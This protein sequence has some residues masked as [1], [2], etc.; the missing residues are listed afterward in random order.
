MSELVITR[1]E[2]E[3]YLGIEHRVIDVPRAGLEAK[4]TNGAGKTSILRA[5]SACLAGEGVKD[6][7]IHVGEDRAQ[8]LVKIGDLI[9]KRT[10]PRGGKA[11]LSVTNPDGLKYPSPQTFLNSLL[12]SSAIDPVGLFLDEPAKRR[13]R[14]Q[15]A[16]PMH[17]TMEQ[18][19]KWVPNL[20]TLP[21]GVSLDEHGLDVVSKIRKIYFDTRA[22]ANAVAKEARRVA[23]DARKRMKEA[24]GPGAQTTVTP[25]EALAQFEKA[26]RDVQELGIRQEQ[27]EGSRARTATAR[28]RATELRERSVKAAADA[29]AKRP[30][31]AAFDAYRTQRDEL[32]VRVDLARAELEK[33]EADLNVVERATDKLV[34]ADREATTLEETAGVL[35]VQAED[36]EAT[37]A[38]TEVPEVS[39]AQIQAANET[40]AKAK[41]LQV[42]A[43]NAAALQ[44]LKADAARLSDAADKA[45]DAAGELDSVVKA[46]TNEAPAE[47]IS[48]DGGIP[49]V[50]FE[51]DSVL[52]DDKKLETC[53]EAEKLRF[54]VKI[55]KRANP[56]SRILICDGV[57]R[58]AP[59]KLEDFYREC[60]TDGW[61]ILATRVDRGELVIEA[62]QAG[63]EEQAAE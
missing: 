48:G 3:N 39:E 1:I 13:A 29:V 45:E 37:L 41:M 2:I 18:L 43:M 44:T 28:Q 55:A 12:G 51:G 27:A 57:E 50:S 23:E 7:D 52:L 38:A 49:G 10:I 54:C 56:K 5:I 62:I 6:T 47:L 36:I 22:G 16:M 25:Q 31:D 30:S 42:L 17:V 11:T 60:I 61:Q 63:V 34:D 24:D 9:V 46:L 15:A 20:R 8:L 58:V 4:G 33:A 14:I 19:Q 40:L 21:M 26:N 32:T 35:A 59:D 53:S